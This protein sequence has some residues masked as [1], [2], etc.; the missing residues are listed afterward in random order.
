[1]APD[2]IQAAY[3][4]FAFKLDPN[5]TFGVFNIHPQ[6]GM[7]SALRPSIIAFID[8]MEPSRSV[9]SHEYPSLLLGDWNDMQ[10]PWAF[11]EVFSPRDD[12]I[13]ILI[14]R[15]DAY[16]TRCEV[17]PTLISAIPIGP[18]DPKHPIQRAPEGLEC[19]FDASNAVSDHCGAYAR[20][21]KTTCEFRSVF[22]NAPTQAG[23]GAA[24]R[25][26]AMPA[27]GGPDF[28]FRW[29]DG[30]TLPHLDV[31]AEWVGRLT[32]SVQV[33]DRR[34]GVT[35]SASATID[36][37]ET[38]PPFDPECMARCDREYRQCI[39]QMPDPGGEDPCYTRW[40]ECQESCRR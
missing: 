31:V 32:W 3:T 14:G 29:S 1:L 30:S 22:I 20:L 37:V 28:E 2:G 36:V 38:N 26:T 11:T 17:A 27:G 35:H 16:L 8:Q 12:P 9:T 4:R 10:W 23:V 5:R 25:L 40:I 33:T 13:G 24:L 34:S 21:V 19:Q 6:A 39:P 15:S 18:G 7:E